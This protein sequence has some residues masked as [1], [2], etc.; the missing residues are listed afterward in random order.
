MTAKNALWFNWAMD[1][2]E[3]RGVV[4]A[5]VVRLLAEQDVTDEIDDRTALFTSGLLDSMSMLRLVAT[6]ERSLSIAISPAEITVD[7]FDTLDG[8]CAA[9]L[10]SMR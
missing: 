7:G 10:S 1:R 2:E 4:R 6:L 3:I 9:V 5:A 8:I